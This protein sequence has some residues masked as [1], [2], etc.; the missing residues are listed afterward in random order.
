[1]AAYKVGSV[2]EKRKGLGVKL[3][4]LLALAHML[5]G[6]KCVKVRVC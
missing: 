4:M 2:A 3:P 5:V 1:L 6:V